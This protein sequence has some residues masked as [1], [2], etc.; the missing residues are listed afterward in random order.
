[1]G[2]KYKAG[3]SIYPWSRI[4]KAFILVALP[5]KRKLLLVV[6]T[7]DTKKKSTCQFNT[8]Q[9]PGDGLICSTMKPHPETAS[10]IWVTIWFILG[11]STLILQDL[12]VSCAV[13]A[14]RGPSSSHILT[15]DPL[16]LWDNKCV[17]F[18][19]IYVVV[20]GYTAR[21]NEQWYLN[22]VPSHP[23]T[24]SFSLKLYC[25]K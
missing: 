12:F 17:L 9:V 1:M 16:E 6:I 8:L 13:T 14:C 24:C 15:S 4:V 22:S 10:G 21:E 2:A 18:E 3:E 11:K 5:A 19:A 20:I 23:K 25:T 7:I